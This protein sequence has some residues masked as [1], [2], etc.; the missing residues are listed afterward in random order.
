MRQILKY[1]DVPVP[2]AVLWS[3]EDKMYLGRDP[4]IKMPACCNEVARGVGKPRFGTPHMDRQR[5]V[6]YND[7]CDLCAKPFKNQTRVSLSHAK[8]N[9]AGA[10]GACV[11]QVEPL[12]H[13]SCAAICIKHCPSLKRDIKAGTLFVRHVLR[14]RT[15]VAF[16]TPAAVAEFHGEP[17][18]KVLG[19]AKV[20]LIK[21]IDRDL[22]WLTG[23]K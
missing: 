22:A 17:V 16:L 11:M 5:E 12:L 18:N 9:F 20:E 15:Q 23:E 6:I 14:H 21:W 3:A 2:Y 10:A 13:K 19:H 7:W 8:V 1:G 4:L